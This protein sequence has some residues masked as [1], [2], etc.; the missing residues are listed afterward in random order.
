[1]NMLPIRAFHL[2]ALSVLV[3]GAAQSCKAQCTLSNWVG[4]SFGSW[5]SAENWNPQVTPSPNVRAKLGLTS[6]YSIVVS[7]GSSACGIDVFDGDVTLTPEE[8]TARLTTSSTLTGCFNSAV[9]V[10]GFDQ[11]GTFRLASG[12]TLKTFGI[13][14]GDDLTN[15]HMELQSGS[16]VILEGTAKKAAP[17]VQLSGHRCSAQTSNAQ[18]TLTLRPSSSITG[19]IESN[20]NT[21]CFD[22]SHIL[23]QGPNAVVNVGW[24]MV[25]GCAGGTSLKDTVIELQGGGKLK[26]QW[27]AEVWG[28]AF[29]HGSGTVETPLLT[30]W[31]SDDL[32]LNADA[33]SGEVHPGSITGSGAGATLTVS[34]DY[35]QRQGIW[36]TF[37]GGKLVVDIAQTDPPLPSDLLLVTGNATIS[38]TLEVRRIGG[39][40]PVPGNRW[41]ILQAN[42]VSGTFQTVEFPS[43]AGC[44]A[45]HLIYCPTK[46]DV[47]LA[48]IAGDVNFDGVVN[49]TDLNIVLANLGA[50]GCGPDGDANFDNVVN[51]TD[52]NIVLANT[53]SS[54]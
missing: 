2:S 19:P 14:L 25:P 47:I 22:P 26:A 40:I 34:G 7:E 20:L 39:S 21:G 13:Q 4:S 1:M 35:W 16:S 36:P 9:W 18:S 12:M 48:S 32:F 17:Y 3:V 43:Y 24:V 53:G 15:G 30:V 44:G 23:I 27:Y 37:N 41:T 46:I 33:I 49:F 8:Q 51:F 38:G 31:S 50:G 10:R 42:S 29:L 54:C 11:A 6:T 5:T 28:H 52:L 45:Y